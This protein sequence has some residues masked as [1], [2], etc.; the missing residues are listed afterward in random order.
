MP[1]SID[2]QAPTGLLP[3]GEEPTR[4]SVRV[5]KHLFETIDPKMQPLEKDDS[6][7]RI[8]RKGRPAMDEVI[9]KV[10]ISLLGAEA[11][12]LPLYCV[13]PKMEEGQK[14]EPHYYFA[15][16]LDHHVTAA[17]LDPKVLE[18]TADE[19]REVDGATLVFFQAAYLGEGDANRRKVI[20]EGAREMTC[21][22]KQM[23]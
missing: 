17:D 4:I 7:T 5:C 18:L 12:A 15:H 20:N 11:S 10:S 23:D 6:F 21:Q 19:A 3:L 1:V 2:I 8:R 16:F 13:W 22:E 14:P 9:R